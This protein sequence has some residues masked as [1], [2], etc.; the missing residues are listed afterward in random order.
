MQGNCELFEKGCTGCN[1]CY[2]GDLDETKKS[3]PSYVEW[4]KKFDEGEQMKI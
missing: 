3:C 1:A 2:E 4:L